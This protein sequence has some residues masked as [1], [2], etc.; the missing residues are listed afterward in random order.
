M[1]KKVARKAAGKAVVLTDPKAILAAA[2]KPCAV[3]FHL[4]NGD[5]AVL[6]LRMASAADR[7]AV[8]AVATGDRDDEGNLVGKTTAEK[9]EEI[10]VAALRATLAGEHTDSELRQ[11][12]AISGG[13]VGPLAM[14]AMRLCGMGG[15]EQ[16]SPLSFGSG[17]ISA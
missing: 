8:Q 15:V 12:L 7:K 4:P 1:K 16:E 5:P 2:A 9:A 17:E 14:R 6:E 13:L 11:L 3:R 10:T